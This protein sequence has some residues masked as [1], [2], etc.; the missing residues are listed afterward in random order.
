MDRA[1][2]PGRGCAARRRAGT[3]LGR[4][5]A[6]PPLPRRPS[7]V[8]VPSSRRSSCVLLWRPTACTVRPRLTSSP[9]SVAPCRAAAAGAPGRC[10]R[11]GLLSPL[12]FPP[13]E[14]SPSPDRGRPTRR[15]VRPSSDLVSRLASPCPSADRDVLAGLRAGKPSLGSRRPP[16][17]QQQSPVLLRRR[18]PA[19]S[20]SVVLGR[21][22][23][24]RHWP[25]SPSPCLPRPRARS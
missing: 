13:S 15:L 9:P 1:V 14:S 4:R 3:T 20:P 6:S 18:L 21:P 22:A 11:L 10:R 19:P 8:D 2:V 7:N 25:L 24:R 17:D 16:A 23:R 12:A 5:P